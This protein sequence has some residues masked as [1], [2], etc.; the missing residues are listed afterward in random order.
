[1]DKERTAVPDYQ[2]SLQQ[3]IQVHLAYHGDLQAINGSR[4]RGPPISKQG[5]DHGVYS[6]QK[7]GYLPGR[8]QHVYLTKLTYT[9]LKND[10]KILIYKN[11]TVKLSCIQL[12]FKYSEYKIR[13][14][15]TLRRKRTDYI[16]CTAPLNFVYEKLGQPE[17]NFYQRPCIVDAF[18]HTDTISCPSRPLLLPLPR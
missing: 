5:C 2:G 4:W 13:I 8:N 6:T 3:F 17:P 18:S 7:V 9:T 12:K 11:T 1:M 15:Q 10:F 16:S 14:Q